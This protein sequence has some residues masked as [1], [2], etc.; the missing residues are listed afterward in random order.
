MGK[1][2]S[3]THAQEEARLPT[4]PPTRPGPYIATP[5]SCLIS[6][7]PDG[8]I[9]FQMDASHVSFAVDRTLGRLARMLRLLG[10][11]TVY[12]PQITTAQLLEIARQ[13][14]RAVLT[15]GDAQKRFPG[16]ANVI[17]LKSEHPT[18]QFREVVRRF[19]LDARAGLWTRCTLCN[20][21]INKVEK[22][23][24]ESQVAPKVFQLYEE[25]YQCGGCGHIYWRGSHAER[26]LKNLSS[27]LEESPGGEERK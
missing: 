9:L 27:I 2:P 3:Q 15:R 25:F 26:I 24:I 5:Q 19:R 18:E 23:T 14:E 1:D 16:I 6:P 8:S 11:D 7:E 4:S 17:S 13:G 21:L 12:S 20:A 22:A 10:Y